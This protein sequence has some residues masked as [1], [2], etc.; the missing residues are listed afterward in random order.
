MSAFEIVFTAANVEVSE[1]KLVDLKISYPAIAP[2]VGFVHFNTTVESPPSNDF[3]VG[4]ENPNLDST[5][6]IS[7][8]VEAGRGLAVPYKSVVLTNL[9]LPLP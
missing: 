3:K 5:A 4:A 9:A 1:I 6:P 8:L 2:F 7:D